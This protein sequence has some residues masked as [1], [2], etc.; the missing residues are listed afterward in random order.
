[1]KR[2]KI[3]AKDLPD[4]VNNSFVVGRDNQDNAMD[5]DVCSSCAARTTYQQNACECKEKHLSSLR[6]NFPISS[7]SISSNIQNKTK[8]MKNFRE[9]LWF[10]QEYYLRRGR[11][12]LSLEFSSHIPFRYWQTVVGKII[13]YR[14]V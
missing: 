11:D 8:V 7:T 12:R 10:W 4:T 5:T 1:M 6:N 14:Y 9:L 2:V 3:L 13:C